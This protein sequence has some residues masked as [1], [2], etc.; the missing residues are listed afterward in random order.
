MIKKP[1]WDPKFKNFNREH[2]RQFLINRT[3]KKG[4]HF[5][6]KEDTLVEYNG[7]LYKPENLM[8]KVYY[9]KKPYKAR[10]VKLCGEFNCINPGCWSFERASNKKRWN[11]KNLSPKRKP[12]YVELIDPPP[13]LR[14]K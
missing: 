4:E 3:E 14:N 9:G 5:I 13:S 8:F 12:E 11:N 7:Y 10:W 6:W 2:A 1:T